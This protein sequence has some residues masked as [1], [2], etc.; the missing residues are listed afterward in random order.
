MTYGI[1]KDLG[2]HIEVSSIAQ[3]GTTFRIYLPLSTEPLV[4][5][6]LA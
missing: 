1:V 3:V 2:G 4:R 5:T 6:A